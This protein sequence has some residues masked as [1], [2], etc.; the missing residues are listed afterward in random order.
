MFSQRLAK[1]A[2]LILLRMA[3]EEL[4]KVPDD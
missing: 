4:E 2:A 3:I 1:D